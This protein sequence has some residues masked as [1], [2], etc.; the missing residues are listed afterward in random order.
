MQKEIIITN[1]API[2]IGPYSQ[3]VKVGEFVF[4]SG[5]LPIDLST[6]E[7]AEGDIEGQTKQ[8]L[9]N[10]MAIL[11]AAGSS[12][13]KVV[14]TIVFMK[15][16]KEFPS[17][18]KIYS[19]YFVESFPARSCVEVSKLPLDAKVEIEAIALIV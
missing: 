3:G 14:K 10:M 5:Q 1:S 9:E 4:V 7:I 12:L 13:D 2:P 11:Q 15:D 18:N 6:G 8:S 17:M 16:M 19:K